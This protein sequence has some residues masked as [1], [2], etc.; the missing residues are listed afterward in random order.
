MHNKGLAT[1][2]LYTVLSHVFGDRKVHR[3]TFE[4]VEDNL[5]MRSWLEDVLEAK[6]EAERRVLERI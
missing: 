6:L 5:P 4:T 3:V 1:E 2:S